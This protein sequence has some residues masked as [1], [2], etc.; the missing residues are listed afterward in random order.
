MILKNKT[1]VITGG[2]GRLANFLAK[3]LSNLGANTILIGRNEDRLIKLVSEL[4]TNSSASYFVCDLTDESQVEQLISQIEKKYSSVD[5]VINAVGSWFSGNLSDHT[6]ETVRSL[7]G[8]NIIGLI[9]FSKN[10]LPLVQKSNYGQILNVISF[11]IFNSPESWP[12]YSAAKSSVQ[13]FT[14]SM[15]SEFENK[16]LR[17][18]ELYPDGM[19]WNESEHTLTYKK[20]AEIIIFMLTQPDDISLEQVNVKKLK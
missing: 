8:S 10:I 2:S 19:S 12:I 4:N 9:L 20:V 5:I 1:V 13:S 11:S 16:T 3:K 6:E 7:F 17:V 18:M 15:R 14:K